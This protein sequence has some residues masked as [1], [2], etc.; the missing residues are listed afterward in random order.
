METSHP[1]FSDILRPCHTI[2]VI[3][4]LRKVTNADT[5][6]EKKSLCFYSIFY[7]LLVSLEK[8]K[9]LKTNKQTNTPTPQETREMVQLEHWLFF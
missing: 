8:K 9:Q 5:R 4:P 6:T 3:Q 1:L 2:W 7:F